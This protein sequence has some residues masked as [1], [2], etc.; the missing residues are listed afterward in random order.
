MTRTPRYVAGVDGSA[1]SEAALAWAVRHARRDGARLHLVH[2]VDPQGGI[3]GIAELDAAESAGEALLSATAARIRSE[4]PGLEVDTRLLLDVPVWALADEAGPDDILVVGTGKTGYVSGRVL[5]S[6]SV[7]FALAATGTVAVV[8]DADPRFRDGVVAG[9]DRVE[10]AALVGR[11]AALEAVDRGTRLTL[12]QAIGADA[13]DAVRS[14]PESPLAIAADAAREV[15]G[16]LEVRSRL[17][18]RPPAEALLDAARGSALLVL[19]PSRE[20]T[21]LG[22]TLHAVLINAN[23]PVLVVRPA[24]A[25]VS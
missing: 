3:R 7:Q 12:I 21:P 4:A 16:M 19:G 1:P 20:R 10:N 6:R 11:R 8:P 2:V 22:T 14:D 18:T 9:V 13:V 23:A 24:P 5:G 17:S 25:L 15:E